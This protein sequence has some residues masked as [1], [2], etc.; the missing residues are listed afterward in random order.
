MH[1]WE[2]K[3][4]VVAML[5]IVAAWII[6]LL[7]YE[8][9]IVP[10]LREAMPGADRFELCQEGLYAAIS[11]RGRTS[12]TSK[13]DAANTPEQTTI[14]YVALGQADGY[15]GPM[16][17]AVG[18]DPSGSVVGIAV[19]DHRETTA[20]FQR[21]EAAD[22]LEALLG[23]RYSDSFRFGEDLDGVTGATLTAGALARSVEA[24]LRDVAGGPLKLPLPP[25]EIAPLEFGI[26]EATL[27]A[28]FVVA[29][30]GY[31]GGSRRRK[32][33]RWLGLLIGLVMLGFVYNKPL[34]LTNVNSLLIGYWPGWRSGLYWYLL[35]VGVLLLPLVLGRNPYCRAI[36]PFGATQEGL[37]LVGQ[38]KPRIPQRYRVYL[39]WIPRFLAWAAILMALVYRN[40]ALANYEVSGTLFN[41]IGSDLQ[42]VILALFLVGSLFVTRPWCNYACPLRAVTDYL[43]LVRKEMRAAVLRTADRTRT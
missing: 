2:R 4:A 24:G 43:R 8:P 21:V 41:L 32:A 3:L 22:L 1:A 10:F 35:A 30:F 5:T 15:G 9:D 7:R 37:A 42:F 29:L 28:L 14:G 33:I 34:T 40:P 6:G 12:D 23:R 13:D 38:S 31:S 17:V 11:P 18:V 26:P 25:Q 27:A 19:V 20:Y 36:C 39:R 16:R